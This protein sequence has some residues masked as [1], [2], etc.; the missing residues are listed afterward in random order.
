MNKL[1]VLLLCISM[2]SITLAA[3]FTPQGNINLRNYYNLTNAPIVNGTTSNFTMYYGNGSQLTGISLSIT[4]YSSFANSSI[5]WGV[6]NLTN[7]TQFEN[8]GG[9][10]T[11]IYS[12][13]TTFIESVFSS[14]STDDLTEGSTNLYDNQ[15]W[16]ETYAD[17]I[18]YG[19]TNPYSF[20][21]STF[22]TFNKT[23]ADTLYYGLTN[24]YSFWNSTFATF[25][26]TYADTLYYG[27]TNPYSFW[28]STFATFNKTYADTIYSP[29]AEPL[30]LHLN[31]DN[32]Y[33]DSS[34]YLYWEGD[35]I[36]FNQTKLETIY[37]NVSSVQ[38]IVGTTAGA[39]GL[40]QIYDILSYNVT[41]AS[42]TPGLDFRMN[43]TG[44][45]DFNQIVLR[46]KSS[47]LENHLMKLQIYDYGSSSWENYGTGGLVADYTVF[48]FLVLDAADHI[49]DGLVQV[50]VYT[51]DNG[52]TNHKHQFD[53]V[54][55]SKG[56]G[57]PSGSEID[58]IWTSEKANYYL[59]TNP[60][61]FWNSTFAT[62]NK[63][64]ADTLYYGITN[65]F[66]FYNST[67]PQEI[68][69]DTTPQ[70]G[71]YLDTNGQNIGATDD[72]IENI[73]VATDSRIYFGDGQESSI[74]YNGTHTII[75]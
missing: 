72:E 23:Y 39:I 17:T 29:I 1:L 49:S 53:L 25:N 34:G 66:S 71:G 65:P 30:S 32:W 48:S 46:Y 37:Y 62:F 69:L 41:E 52:N 9:K 13:L 59:L 57:T 20:W 16:N 51:S 12:W 18:Y 61:S 8:S 22:A 27:I 7:S 33:N 54:Q 58:P 15:S 19:L 36:T 40:I 21:N 50:R 67:N 4:N 43:F 26:K 10:L 56:L 35:K 73:Y 70:L 47:S 6:Y 42:G 3:D 45:E 5:Y 68:V 14:K 75:G 44:V 24:P 11:I 28:N 63:T 55:I 60:Y 64:Y 2:I 31:Q 74:Y 38:A